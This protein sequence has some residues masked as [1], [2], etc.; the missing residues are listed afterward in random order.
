MFVK[1]L[2][3]YALIAVIAFVLAQVLVS[4]VFRVESR[5]W[6][7]PEYWRQLVKVSEVLRL[8]NAHYVDADPAQFDRLGSGALDG[9]LGNLDRYSDYMDTQEYDEFEVS[10]D[11]YY[12][13]IGVQIERLNR[14]IT[15]TEVF[16]QS[17]AGTVGMQVGDQIVAVGAEDARDMSL[18]EIVTLLR[19]P[20]GSHAELTV[21]RPGTGETLVLSVQRARIDYPTLRDVELSD[22]GIGYL[23]L[24]QFSMRSADELFDA[25]SEL[26]S[27]GM[28][29]LIIDL[30]NNPG[31]ILPGAVEVAGAF[32]EAN[33]V[34][35]T[36]RSRGD[37]QGMAE[38][39]SGGPRG[40]SY[41]IAI[42][43]NPFSASASEIV[44]GAL[45][46]AGRAIIVGETSV[47][48]GS[49]QSI[50]PINENEGLRLTT[51]RYYLPSGRT[52]HD[53][54]VVPDIRIALTNE[55][56]LAQLAQRAYQTLSDAEFEQRFGVSRLPDRQRDAAADVLRGVIAFGRDDV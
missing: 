1:I 11:Q 32:M 6:L 33:A 14:R 49:V 15:V 7:S 24:T 22:E 2:F 56:R 21:Y 26:E 54:G 39:A 42:L 36:V 18:A 30:R 12:A 20:E 55:E 48:K 31:G 17:P 4:L 46:D 29:G 13:G 44:A 9:L 41:P 50:I 34:V 25:L 3:R 38:R 43:I 16:D 28:R 5:A 40:I 52:I 51:A 37:G 47:G 23:R 10:A 45:Q 35:V 19:G 53:S 8:V 27:S